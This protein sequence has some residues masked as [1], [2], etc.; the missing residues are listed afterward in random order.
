MEG[1]RWEQHQPP[2]F[3]SHA[4]Q[5]LP[6]S[7]EKKK[8][9]SPLP[10]PHRIEEHDRGYPYISLLLS[11]PPVRVDQRVFAIPA[12]GDVD[13]FRGR[14]RAA[15]APL[16]SPPS[17]SSEVWSL[18]RSSGFISMPECGVSG[19]LTPVED[20]FSSLLP[21][22][23]SM[24]M[25]LTS[26]KSRTLSKTKRGPNGI[27]CTRRNRRPLDDL[28]IFFLLRSRTIGR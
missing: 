4:V 20:P 11:F 28:G 14:R 19:V 7:V 5:R 12:L 10:L 27:S 13:A 8:L 3:R 21:V 1:I 9:S 15:V 24:M 26:S 22:L 6:R 23:W 16:R 2:G 17:V 25:V 18:R